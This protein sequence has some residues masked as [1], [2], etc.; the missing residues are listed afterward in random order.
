MR[1]PTVNLQD[2]IIYRQVKSSDLPRLEWNGE[3]THFRNVFKNAF[4]KS[5]TGKT[6]LWV[7]EIKHVGLIGQAFVQ[8]ISSRLDLANG[9][10]R[11]YIY[12]FRFKENY[13]NIGIGSSLL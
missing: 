2:K 5:K 9:V 6:K 7:V 12:A 11:A 13:Q 1:I 3:F 4:E 10:D 8:L